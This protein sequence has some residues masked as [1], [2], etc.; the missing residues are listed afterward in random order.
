MTWEEALAALGLRDPFVD[1]RTWAEEVWGVEGAPLSAIKPS[2]DAWIEVMRINMKHDLNLPE[3]I[4]RKHIECFTLSAKARL[5]DLAMAPKV[6]G[7]A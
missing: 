1:G 6:V 2:L 7:H 5:Y 3:P 4:I